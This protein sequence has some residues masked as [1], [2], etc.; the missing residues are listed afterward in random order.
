MTT[1]RLAR[2]STLVAV[3]AAVGTSEAQ[4]TTGTIVGTVTDSNGGVLPGATVN[5]KDV[6]QEYLDD[7]GHRR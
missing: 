3:L 4:V 6:G 1:M 7:R 2:V 5:I